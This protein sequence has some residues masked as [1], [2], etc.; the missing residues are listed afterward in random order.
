MDNQSRIPNVDICYG[1]PALNTE[2]KELDLAH[3]CGEGCWEGTKRTEF[4]S[5]P[6]P[7]L[8]CPYEL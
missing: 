3:K 8:D 6:K 2:I 5:H 7:G 1:C 4:N